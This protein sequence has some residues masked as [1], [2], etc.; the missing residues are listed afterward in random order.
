MSVDS[1][2]ED[3]R[4][5]D[6]KITSLEREQETLRSRC[7]QLEHVNSELSADVRELRLKLED[8]EQHSRCANIEIVG[9]PLTQGKNV[10]ECLGKIAAVLEVP[11]KREDVS[12]A[13]RL[14]LFSKKH[15]H[16][17]VIVQFVS[18]TAK[19]IWIAAAR[20]KKVLDAK[21]I[22]ASLPTSSVYINDHLTSYNKTLL[23]RARRLLREKKLC[24]A[25]FFN[26]KVLI[27]E[28]EGDETVRVY[29]LEKMD[30]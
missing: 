12:I 3:F 11:F 5:L 19:E 18:R 7:C 6:T 26:G 4:K 28:K 9:L 29:T 15:Q 25:G 23:G 30:I 2:K 8:G 20:Q 16:P 13:H 27:R 10:Y 24:F 14:R 21:T 22:A 1:L 17:P